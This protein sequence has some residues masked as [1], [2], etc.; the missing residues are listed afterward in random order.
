VF[1]LLTNAIE[2]QTKGDFYRG[3]KPEPLRR[4]LVAWTGAQVPA[5]RRRAAPLQAQL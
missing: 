1:I 5:C 3:A 4:V 2:R